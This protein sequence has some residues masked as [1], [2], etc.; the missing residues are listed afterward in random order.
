MALLA[1]NF[2][3]DNILVRFIEE[4]TKM[5]HAVSKKIR[6]SKSESLARLVDKLYSL[7]LTMIEILT[8]LLN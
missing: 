2:S 8:I 7:N 3:T 4:N 5:K 6:N 1:H